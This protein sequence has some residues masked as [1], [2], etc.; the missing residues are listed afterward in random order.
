MIA[1]GQYEWHEPIT[2]MVAYRIVSAHASARALGAKSGLKGAIALALARRALVWI[3]RARQPVERALDRWFQ[4]GRFAGSA[5]QT[6]DYLRPAAP[7]RRG[8]PTSS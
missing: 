4:Q 8:A 1:F 5:T 7:V 6:C 2:L 3:Y